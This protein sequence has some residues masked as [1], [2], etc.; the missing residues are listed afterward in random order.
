MP[1]FDADWKVEMLQMQHRFQDLFGRIFS[2][3]QPITELYSCVTGK[4]KG[5]EGIPS[6]G[7]SP[8]KVMDRWGGYDQTTWF[9][10]YVTIPKQFS[11]KRVVALLNPCAHSHVAGVGPHYESGEGLAY[12]NGVP[13]Q[14]ID[15]NHECLVLADK[16]KGGLRF[17]IALE[18]CP[19]TRFDSSHVFSQADI[20]VMHQDLWDFYWDGM[21]YMDA[22]KFMSPTDTATRRLFALLFESARMM[23]IDNQDDEALTASVV[24]ARQFLYKGLKAFPASEHDGVL[25]LIGHSHIDTAWLWPLRETK[26][27]VGRTFSTMLRLME[28]YPEFHFSASQ[29]E[30]YMFVKE[31][32]PALWKDI[33]RRVRQGR[34][35]PCGATWVEQ[36]SNISGGEALVRQLLYGNR[37]YEKEFG[38]RSTVAWL[39]DAFGFPWSLPQLLVRAGMETFHTIKI[40]WSKYTKFPY[41]YFWWQGADGTRIR[42]VMP[43]VNYNGD[44]TPEQCKRQW[45][46]FQQ[47]HLVSEIPFSFGFGDGGGGPTHKMIEYGKR[48]ANLVGLPKCSFSRTEDCFER[49]HASVAADKLPVHNG[50]LYLE[51]HRGC[52]TTQSRTKRNNRKCEWLLHNVEWLCSW[53]ALHGMSYDHDTINAAWRILLTHQF[54]D[55]LPGSSITEVYADAD[56]NYQC[57]RD[58][59]EPLLTAAQ[60]YL[61]EKM[62]T[63]GKGTPIVV[64]NPVSWMRDDVVCAKVTLPKGDFHILAPDGS[65]AVS[66][67]TGA[68]EILFEA[69]EVSALGYA[70]YRL[71]PGTANAAALPVKATSRTLENQY[72]KV[73]LDNCGRFKRVFDKQANR[74]V[75]A[76]GKCGNVLQLF[77]DR[78]AQHDAWD[79]D[80]NFEETLYEPDKAE[81]M[82]IVEQGPVRAVIRVVRCT[83]KSVFTQDITLY[84]SSPRIEVNTH[85]DWHEKRRLLKVAFPVDILA[86]RATYHIQ[87]AAVERS[88]HKNTAFDHARF[89]VPAHHWADLSEADY[90]VSLLNDCKYGYDVRDNVLRLSLLRSPI[91]PDPHADEGEHRFTYALLP[92]QGDWRTGSVHEGYELNAPLLATAAKATASD[93]PA[94]AALVET[95]RPNVIVETVKQAEDSDA[96]VVRLYEAHGARGPMKVQFGIPVSKVVECNLMED[97]ETEIPVDSDNSIALQIKPFEVRSFLIY[98]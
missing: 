85:V 91:D 98:T 48:Y 81:S 21:A 4:T 7:W 29:P 50:E 41:G 1:H 69:R 45:N 59:L 58:M 33:K 71:M 23:D 66:Q 80:Y 94:A 55:I 64:W 67:K 75:I 62:D 61:V 87:F 90:G 76:A 89:E 10:M 63:A 84:A 39:P 32:Y 44:P 27:K 5:P 30:L 88:T 3:R 2:Q 79:I 72:V 24:K 78:P 74:E 20:A 96:L 14:G 60:E 34:W 93:Q 12:V 97:P 15:R 31:K 40:S 36:D 86:P 73:T 53:A 17:D 56:R 49:M 47:K 68:D 52:Q 11:G 95:D 70:V 19:S 8:F 83:E 9:R 46:D 37:F 38:K 57:I 35:E 92:H 51:L 82:E 16:A 77:E 54:H 42:A 43:P 25:A 18:C 65:V 6:S 26:R 13:R 22:I 28:Q